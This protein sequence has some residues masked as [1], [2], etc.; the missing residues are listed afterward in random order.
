MII[1]EGADTGMKG[2]TSIIL[3]H[4]QRKV[5]VTGYDDSHVTKDLPIGTTATKVTD[6]D[7]N[8]LILIENEQICYPDQDISIMS[9]NQ[10]RAFGVDVDDCPSIHKR[11]GIPGRCNMIVDEY[12][13][14]FEYQFS[15]KSIIR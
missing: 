4:T 15:S 7:G 5:N 13:I 8:S 14:P 3:E 6:E 2:K 11:D 1:D 9:V 12:T 10:V